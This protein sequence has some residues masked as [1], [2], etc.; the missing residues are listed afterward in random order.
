MDTATDIQKREPKPTAKAMEEKIKRLR[1]ERK[2]KLAL[3]TRKK[4][5]EILMTDKNNAEV[6][7]EEVLFIFEKFFGEFKALN[8]EIL[9]LLEEDDKQ[10][11]QCNW[12]LPKCLEFEDFTQKTE[13]WIEMA[14]TH[15]KGEV[16][17]DVDDETHDD[18]QP[19][20]SISEVIGQT[21]RNNKA[22]SV[23]SYSSRASSASSAH[24]KLEA[25]R[26]ELLICAVF[27]KKR[28]DIELEEA[29]L[30]AHKEPLELEAK[31]SASDQDK[32][33]C[34]LRGWSRWHE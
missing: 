30:K 27:L 33:L 24:L 32:S 18:V 7:K 19:S 16:C 3:L 25:E 22:S 8:T 28:H 15:C 6:V 11:D 13:S 21:R 20:D 4:E 14:L 26:E 34:R 1:N 9:P 31:I 10:E 17:G 23:L 12:Y 5:I 2:G 29:H